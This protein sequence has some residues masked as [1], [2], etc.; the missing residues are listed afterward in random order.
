MADA[1][2]EDL[3]PGAEIIDL[4]EGLEHE[5]L[6]PGSEVVDLQPEPIPEYDPLTVTD[7]LGEFQLEP[8]VPFRPTTEEMDQFRA[9]DAQHIRDLWELSGMAGDEDQDR[10]NGVRD[11]AKR[12]DI[13]FAEANESYDAIKDSIEEVGRD[14]IK[15]MLKNPGLHQLMLERPEA[16][17]AVM[18]NEQM[19]RFSKAMR[20]A[21]AAYDLIGAGVLAGEDPTDAEKV[22]IEAKK[23]IFERFAK[24]GDLGWLGVFGFPTEEYEKEREDI[25]TP[26]YESPLRGGRYLQDKFSRGVAQIMELDLWG[27]VHSRGLAL[28]RARRTG[29]PEEIQAA[30]RLWWKAETEAREWADQQETE[31]QQYYGEEP[32][33]IGGYGQDVGVVL[34]TAPSQLAVLKGAVEGGVWGAVIAAGV[35]AVGGAV[36]G[37][38]AGLT[39]GVGVLPGVVSG[40]AVGAK[41]GVYVA[42]N[43]GIAAGVVNASYELE[44]A[45]AFKDMIDTKDD[46]GK[47]IDFEIALAMSMVVGAVNAGIELAEFGVEAKALGLGGLLGAAK[48]QR[49]K[50]L[51]EML[52]N[53]TARQA[54]IRVVGAVLGRGAL[55]LKHAGTEGLEE[56]GQH[57]GTS[58]GIYGAASLSAGELQSVDI[59]ELASG[60]TTAAGVGFLAGGGMGIGGQMMSGAARGAHAATRRALRG[61]PEKRTTIPRPMAEAMQH[62]SESQ[63]KAAHAGLIIDFVQ[64]NDAKA[65]AED[66]QRLIEIETKDI[67]GE[68]AT[69]LHAD[70]EVLREAPSAQ[71]K[72]LLGPE[73][74]AMMNKALSDRIDDAGMRTTLAI[75]M[76]DIVRAGQEANP[77]LETLKESTTTGA[78]LDTAKDLRQFQESMDKR[79]EEYRK[80]DPDADI[81]VTTEGEEISLAETKFVE[82]LR[83]QLMAT[84]KHTKE[85]AR[86]SVSF[87]RAFIRTASERLGE[88]ETR[89]VFAD[90]TAMVNGVSMAAPVA[91]SAEFHFERLRTMT[92]EQRSR[93]RHIRENEG[94]YDSRAFLTLAANDPR[95]N[96]AHISIEGIKWFN[97]LGHETGDLAYRLMGQAIAKVDP[98]VARWGGDFVTMVDHTDAASLEA[99]I[100]ENITAELQRVNPELADKIPTLGAIVTIEPRGDSVTDAALRAA[101]AT[102]KRKDEMEA[103]KVPERATRGER[104]LG[105]PVET[106]AELA[107]P[108][109][110]SPR[111]EV[112]QELVAETEGM[113]LAEIFNEV[114]LDP[115][116]GMLT[117]AA[118][119]AM[120]RKA[121]QVALDIDGLG[122]VNDIF[123]EEKGNLFIA[124]FAEMARLAGASV[125]NMAH[126]GG[127]EFVAEADTKEQAQYFLDVLA[128]LVQSRSRSPD[129]GISFTTKDGREIDGLQFSAGI[130]KTYDAADK[131]SNAAK[132]EK[133]TDPGAEARR[134]SGRSESRRGRGME[135]GGRALGRGVRPVSPPGI[136]EQSWGSLRQA[137]HAR[138]VQERITLA[139]AEILKAGDSQEVARRLQQEATPEA[140]AAAAIPAARLTRPVKAPPFGTNRKALDT[141][142]LESFPEGMDNSPSEQ[143]DSAYYAWKDDRGPKPPQYGAETFGGVNHYLGLTGDDRVSSLAEA[144]DKLMANRRNWD[145]VAEAVE[146]LSGEVE[147]LAELRMPEDYLVAMA[148]ENARLE[149]FQRQTDADE[150]ADFDPD[151]IEEP[152]PKGEKKL[153]QPA[154]TTLFQPGPLWYSAAL[155]AVNSA[156]QERNSPQAWLALLTKTAGVRKEE[157]EFLGIPE[158][159][160]K[161]GK[162]V[163]RDELAKF[164]DANQL[165][166]VERILSD[167]PVYEEYTLGGHEEGSYRELTFQLPGTTA[168]QYEAP[169]F[170]G[171]PGLVAHA[172]ISTHKTT[173]GES[174]LVV[175]EIQSDLHQAGR[176][177]GYERRKD[178]ERREVERD[179]P[180]AVRD[181]VVAE[182]EVHAQ[183]LQSKAD[184]FVGSKQEKNI[185]SQRAIRVLNRIDDVRMREYLSFDDAAWVLEQN[186]LRDAARNMRVRGERRQ[187]FDQ[188]RIPDAPLKTTWDE[189][190]AKRLIRL[191]ADEG[192]DTIAWTPG[193][194]QAK[195]YDLSKQVDSIQYDPDSGAVVAKRGS[196]IV[197]SESARTE[198]DLVSLVG[199]EL[200]SKLLASER[201]ATFPDQVTPDTAL[202]HRLEGEDLRVGGEGMR[203]FYDRRLKSVFQK[204]VKKYGGKVGTVKIG[205]K[206][207]A[208]VSELPAADVG[209]SARSFAVAVKNQPWG[210]GDIVDEAKRQGK[211]RPD[212][213]ALPFGDV[214]VEF[215]DGSLFAQ[216]GD[217]WAVFDPLPAGGEATDLWSVSLPEKLRETVIREG[218]PLFQDDDA[219]PSKE[220]DSRGLVSIIQDGIRKSF[221]IWLKEKAD[222][223]T[224]AHESSHA[225]LEIFFSM[226]DHPAAS[227]ALKK[228]VATILR[229]LGAEHSSDVTGDMHEVFADQFERYLMR[230]E[231]PSVELAGPMRSAEMWMR[232]VYKGLDEI[233]A[234]LDP[235]L[236]GVFDRMLATDRQIK[237]LQ[238]TLGIAEPMWKSHIEANKSPKEFDDYIEDRY[239]NTTRAAAVGRR[240]MA[241][242][243]LRATKAWETDEF[244]ALNAEA[245]D[246]WTRRSDVQAWRFMQVGEVTLPDGLVVKNSA[247]GKIHRDT[248]VETMGADHPLG[249]RLK[250]R[251]ADNGDHPTSIAERFGFET[252]REM[253]EAVAALP[254]EKPWVR[255]RAEEMMRERHPEI[256]GEMAELDEKLVDVLLDDKAIKTILKDEWFPLRIH[257]PDVRVMKAS[258]GVLLTTNDALRRTAEI[259]VANTPVRELFVSKVLQRLEASANKA[260]IAILD[261]NEK[262]AEAAKLRQAL[263]MHSYRETRDALGDRKRFDTIVKRLAKQDVR[264]KMAT[265]GREFVD[266]SDQILEALGVLDVDVDAEA[267]PAISSLSE[268]LGLAFDPLEIEE[269]LRKLPPPPDN[270]TPK[271]QRTF[272]D[273]WRDLSVREMR[274]LTTALTDLYTKGRDR[275]SFI[276][277]GKRVDFGEFADT[278]G[279][280]AAE[281]RGKKPEIDPDSLIDAAGAFGKKA[282]ALFQEP[283]DILKWISPT[284]YDA[285]W[286]DGYMRGLKKKD[287]I[288]RKVMD[289]Y[290]KTWLDMPKEIRKR[291]Y[292]LLDDPMVWP[293]DVRLAPKF[294]RQFLIMVALYMGMESNR[295]RLLGGYKWD[296]DQVFA[297]ID[298]HLEDAEIAFINRVWEMNDEVIWP[299][300]VAAYEEEHGL[301]P[302]KLPSTEITLPSGRVLRGGYMPAKYHPVTS[303]HGAA[304]QAEATAGKYAKTAAQISISKTFT[305]KRAERYN[306]IIL[307]DWNTVPSH[308][309]QTAHY[310]AFNRFI[311][312]G[313]MILNSP[314]IRKVI[315][316]RLGPQYYSQLNDPQIG[317]LE[318]AANPYAD[319][320][321]E[322]MDVAKKFFSWSRRGVLAGALGMRFLLAANAHIEP[323]AISLM[324][325]LG[326]RLR[327]SWTMASFVKA[328]TLVGFYLMRRR[329]LKRGFEPK[330]RAENIER[331]IRAEMQDFGK[332]GRRGIPVKMLDAVRDFQFIFFDLYDRYSTTIVWDSAYT[333][334]KHKGMDEKKAAHEADE[335]VADGLP[336]Q[337]RARQAVALAEKR[338]LSL[339]LIF[340]TWFVKQNNMAMTTT[341]EA[342]VRMAKAHGYIPKAAHAVGVGVALGMI[343]AGLMVSVSAEIIAAHGPEPDEEDEEWLERK[344]IAAPFLLA[345]V[346][347]QFGEYTVN[348][349]VSEKSRAFSSRSI[350][351]AGVEALYKAA[352][353]AASGDADDYDRFMALATALGVGTGTFIGGTQFRWTSEYLRNVMEGGADTAPLGVASGI[354]A[355]EREDQPANLFTIWD[356]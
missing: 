170:E 297:W 185:L 226:A 203:Q 141:I 353:K 284:L 88:A 325:G 229:V 73:W 96:V 183:R 100:S 21:G 116:T 228:D 350:A 275:H 164:I 341:D 264:E 29:T 349:I 333:F 225:Y 304:Q 253:L 55:V 249:R 352:E 153:F 158:W 263:A 44:K 175:E 92:A 278:V 213:E 49:G 4:G 306:D 260:Q 230:G 342:L 161:Q 25:Q 303:R 9:E 177:K 84:G 345:P 117:Q 24:A 16:T 135:A 251:L 143:A 155:K 206:L 328:H 80:L 7:P 127:D 39:T 160:G 26:Q 93:L 83:D 115:R 14:P 70:P 337:D 180:E 150:N 221:G 114:I 66:A 248:F 42:G 329:A 165:E 346:L 136:P 77:L 38:V 2:R 214:V 57:L 101:E 211:R 48:G 71:V 236:K 106:A 31:R 176:E 322:V 23:K 138:A 268:D 19:G 145:A 296:E 343:F 87:W 305:Q 59:G 231:T 238:Q 104:P 64:T 169:H 194:V 47:P 69:H 207:G 294:D 159:L 131:A 277:N 285:V 196:E 339:F 124:I 266:A 269:I 323:L 89:E 182:L 288:L 331:G 279:Q 290:A 62:Y 79:V 54:I 126:R 261:G 110:P 121:H 174:V 28:V 259:N 318:R 217:S 37:G 338:S 163:S 129:L 52:R 167:D 270:P 283:R 330:H 326:G 307:L 112:P 74:A 151:V 298:T 315:D 327:L 157:V 187:R 99:A 321:P 332:L 27:D 6:P 246:E 289:F 210:V 12:G 149:E 1:D 146:I 241:A 312:Q 97:A 355:G 118:Y 178:R 320:A 300:V 156:K 189:F 107:L 254:D 239:Q 98:G 258:Q 256:E 216:T 30:E 219:D 142:M 148:E 276:H 245:A 122:A 91:K 5:A 247:L 166:V 291:R 186:G 282:I 215:H 111:L 50:V 240:M 257:K 227:E 173:D 139:R 237:R 208:L 190:V 201:T 202:W 130:G 287:E 125:M 45:G 193:D 184:A 317:F 132:S 109:E 356:R 36:A 281:R 144:F 128:E 336:P 351:G 154:A 299:E 58:T 212:L 250:K 292:D 67:G 310:A 108:T 22:S 235:K 168:E 181:E 95:P 274:V 152:D 18:H 243:E 40:A 271:Q 347:G 309:M 220:R 340:Q 35:G 280:E 334:A 33:G 262:L 20:V 195:R 348:Q 324:T 295:E 56:A 255:E 103:G 316:E 72:A 65:S 273:Q 133:A 301:P 172:R 119:D 137:R 123:G 234:P 51:H 94:V 61:R 223:S 8:L 171:A 76:A 293:A 120:P 75:P 105:I 200:A 68:E 32:L 140:V 335:A 113:A 311:R 244:R 147:G 319:S 34:E 82:T 78:Q 232:E 3:P 198:S 85:Q 90:M 179:T 314:E 354:L 302:K 188:N 11:F 286:T 204:Q 192:F 252:G 53:P 205:R 265:G 46:Q 41:G 191:A 199:K 344:A 233:D 197:I 162:S 86:Q 267:R 209:T 13:D 63:K 308:V 15:W 81:E 218:M 10:Y 43:L 242:A 17:G 102:N 222:L 272:E 134:R 313:K 60:V 224:F